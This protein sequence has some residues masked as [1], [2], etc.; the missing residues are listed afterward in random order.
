MTD[1]NQVHGKIDNGELAVNKAEI[2]DGFP[3]FLSHIHMSTSHR[4][5]DAQIEIILDLEPKKKYRR[6][7]PG[8]R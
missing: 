2:K 3:F 7:H 4:G 1:S 5:E 8:P 6:A